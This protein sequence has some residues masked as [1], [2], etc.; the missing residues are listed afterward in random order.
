MPSYYA[1]SCIEIS[2]IFFTFGAVFNTRH[3][4]FGFKRA[5]LTRIQFLTATIDSLSISEQDSE[6]MG[7]PRL[8]FHKVLFTRR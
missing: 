3:Y 8:I 6:L 5:L 2:Q 4:F 1:H 7:V